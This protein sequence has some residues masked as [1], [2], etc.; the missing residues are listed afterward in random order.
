MEFSEA[1]ELNRM[2]KLSKNP[3][4]IDTARK[5]SSDKNGEFNSSIEN[6]LF[7]SPPNTPPTDPNPTNTKQAKD[8][9]RKTHPQSPTITNADSPIEIEP[10]YSYKTES[11]AGSRKQSSLTKSLMRTDLGREDVLS[12]DTTQMNI[13]L[14]STKTNLWVTLPKNATGEQ[15]IAK[16]IS[17]Y[18]RCGKQIEF[19][20]PNGNVP[21]AYELYMVDDD[22]NLPEFDL[23]IDRKKKIRD[24][25]VETLAFCAIENYL[26]VDKKVEVKEPEAVEEGDGINLKIDFDGQVIKILTNP[27]STLKDAL[28]VVQEKTPGSGYL[29]PDDYQFKIWVNLEEAL[30]QED[31]IVDINLQ[32]KTI[33]TTELKLRK[34][35]FADSPTHE[36]RQTARRMTPSLKEE[37]KFDPE[38]NFMSKAQACAYHE[39]AVIKTNKRGK[40]QIRVLGIDQLRLYNMTQSEAK[41]NLKQK[42]ATN[43]EKS[44][45][46]NKLV[47]LF[48]QV[49]HHPEIPIAN[50]H[51]V[52]QDE[53]NLSCFYIEY[54]EGNDRKTK[55][56]E[57]ESSSIAS[58]VI[59]KISKLMTLNI[60]DTSKEESK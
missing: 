26:V 33:G 50:I 42:A 27:E 17:L 15:L 34:K 49:T 20:L 30:Q 39:Y 35:S 1:Y 54:T 10:D 52:A 31:C 12:P 32:I 41:K 43:A 55:L 23:L 28:K 36:H 24:L 46:R 8:N 51:K 5:D 9:D 13:F 59:A 53:K 60:S 37:S 56:Y 16:I 47:G 57:T 21:E 58:E 38:M 48:R 25:G 19:P 4:R 6:D 22:T 18:S 14:F 44:V 2:L 7:Y 45:M 11:L 29:N 40:R 3:L